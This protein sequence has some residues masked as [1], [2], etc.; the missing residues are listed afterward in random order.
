LSI[1]RLSALQ[2]NIGR[3]PPGGLRLEAGLDLAGHEQESLLHVDRSLCGGLNE[4][5]AEGGSKFLKINRYKEKN[6]GKGDEKG[7]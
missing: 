6:I 4:V 5:N 1:H 7:N 3:V 2:R